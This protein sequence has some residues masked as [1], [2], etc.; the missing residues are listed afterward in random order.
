LGVELDDICYGFIIFLKHAE[1]EKMVLHIM[2]KIEAVKE[3]FGFAI[4]SLN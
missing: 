3:E 2:N 4:R 1:S